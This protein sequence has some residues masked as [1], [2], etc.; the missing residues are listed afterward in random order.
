MKAH[1]TLFSASIPGLGQFRMQ[2]T[3]STQTQ[4][5]MVRCELYL[6]LHR[7][8]ACWS[9][10]FPVWGIFIFILATSYRWHFVEW[11][12]T[13]A[14]SDL[15]R[16]VGLSLGL[17]QAMELGVFA[18]DTNRQIL[19]GELCLIGQRASERF[20]AVRNELAEIAVL[21]WVQVLLQVCTSWLRSCTDGHCLAVIVVGAWTCLIEFRSR[22]VV[23]GDEKSN[24]V[25][26]SI[27]ALR[28]HLK[29]QAKQ[30]NES[31]DWIVAIVRVLMIDA[32]LTHV[33][34]Q[35]TSVSGDASHWDADMIVHLQD[36]LLMRWQLGCC[37]FECDQHGIVGRL[38]SNSCWAK[39]DGFHGV[40]DLMDASLRTP[41]GHIAI[42][43]IAKLKV[44]KIKII[45][46]IRQRWLVDFLFMLLG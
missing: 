23:A 30:V 44:K 18:N 31:T 38:E 40:L 5:T 26:S 11:R 6:L 9:G 13:R 12:H 1:R 8:W 41:D 33:T 36:L 45:T 34:A 28:A 21:E 25:W 24:T 20:D 7:L 2:E 4:S 14:M 15:S 37:T 19:L 27:V 42:V 39:L 16:Q 29:L 17:I 3:R 43:L 32:L 10:L 46:Q 22:V 35:N